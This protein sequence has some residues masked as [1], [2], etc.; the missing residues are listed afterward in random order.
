VPCAPGETGELL[1]RISSFD[2]LRAYKGYQGDVLRP[3]DAYF[4]TGDLLKVTSNGYYYFVDRIGD[5]YRWKGENV[6][7]T[8]V[9]E[10]ITA[11][12][13][14]CEAIVCMHRL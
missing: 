8:E 10:V 4:R 14:V 2:P 7:S 1:S 11:F 13:A 5:T 12:P 3:N 9:A 6:A